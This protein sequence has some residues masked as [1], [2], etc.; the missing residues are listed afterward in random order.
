MGVLR[1]RVKK[2]VEIHRFVNHPIESNCFVVKC[3]GDDRV[4]IV[5]PGS[6][7]SKELFA[8]LTQNNYTINSVILTHE[9]FDH[10]A[11][12]NGLKKHFDFKLIC[13][14]ETSQAISNNRL[15]LSAYLDEIDSF[16][17]E[18][19]SQ[20]VNDFEELSF[21]NLLVRFHKTP[22]H[23]PGSMCFSFGN[24]FFTGDTILNN[25]KTSLNLPRSSKEL[26]KL[27]IEKL[28]EFF[29]DM[30]IIWPGHGVSFF[31]AG[32]K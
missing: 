18:M 17:I 14:R 29:N 30:T 25:T 1:L 12:V 3:E 26:Y 7:D 28:C 32:I 20:I 8:F 5:D 19:P 21:G 13:S 24:N 23:S 10:C 15:N 27:S 6:P 4:I 9:H 11:G 2:V 16:A 22:G 31:N